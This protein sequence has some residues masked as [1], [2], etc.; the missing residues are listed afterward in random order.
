MTFL[1]FSYSA[2][3][4]FLKLSSFYCSCSR[5]SFFFAA[6]STFSARLALITA[7]LAYAIS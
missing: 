7:S 1:A 5:L 4:A 2:F 6:I 3:F